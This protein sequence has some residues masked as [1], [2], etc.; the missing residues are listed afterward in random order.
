MKTF[1]RLVGISLISFATLTGCDGN[2]GAAPIPPSLSGW[3]GGASNPAIDGI[4]HFIDCKVA[5]TMELNC[6]LGTN[7]QGF[8]SAIQATG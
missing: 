7:D 6:R 3:W 1:T 8:L 2:G 5:E 4:R